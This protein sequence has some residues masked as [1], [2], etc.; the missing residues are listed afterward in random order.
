M[1]NSSAAA[2]VVPLRPPRKPRRVAVAMS[3][4]ERRENARRGIANAR[5]ALARARVKAVPDGE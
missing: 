5:A 3:D 4:Q 2:N 1:Q